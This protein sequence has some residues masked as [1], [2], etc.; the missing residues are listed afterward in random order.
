[1]DNVSRGIE[2]DECAADSHCRAPEGKDDQIGDHHEVNA[3]GG[4]D[5]E[6]VP[7][8]R[9]VDEESV[10]FFCPDEGVVAQA[11]ALCQV[12]DLL[13]LGDRQYNQHHDEEEGESS[14][15]KHEVTVALVD[16][17][18]ALVILRLCHRR[19]QLVAVSVHC[20]NWARVSYG[21]LYY[22]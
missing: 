21:V 6:E 4:L 11:L 13:V 1:M 5:D 19:A 17:M 8:G 3:D 9:V 22:G 2:E 16:L 12:L 20:L 15:S 14:S 10:D 7:P 18:H